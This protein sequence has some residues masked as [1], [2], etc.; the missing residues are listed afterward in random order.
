MDRINNLV[1]AYKLSETV[2]PNMSK[3]RLVLNNI[4]LYQE[5]RER[6]LQILF[7]G[8]EELRDLNQKDPN[9]LKKVE[10]NLISQ[11]DQLVFNYLKKVVL[12]MEVSLHMKFNNH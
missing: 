2:V 8:I 3:K 9:L 12:E 4:K 1:K 5:V 11:D 10:Q 6:F 7:Y